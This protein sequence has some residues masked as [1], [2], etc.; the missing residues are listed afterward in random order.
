MT[1]LQVNNSVFGDHGVSSRLADAFVARLRESRP[2]ARVIRR[3]LGTSPVPQV[4]AEAL[5]A[6]RTA[7]A[8]RSAEQA[9]DAA[10]ADELIGELMAADT[11]IIGAPTYNFNVP[12]S[13][14]AW[15]DHV[16]RAG[17][18][19]RYTENGPE[20]LL[21]GREAYVFVA[22]GGHHAATER[23]FATPWLRYMLGFLGIDQVAFTFAE[24]Q[25]MG[26]EA[27]RQGI[28]SAYARITALAA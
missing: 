23:D 7:P 6:G 2:D 13:L 28:E 5:A 10:F 12:S 20:G 4:T 21:A 18:T 26:D 1:I 11:L 27:S 16:A 9:R 24:G 3:D 22:S 25:A 8:E 19:F 17:T 15:F 14:K